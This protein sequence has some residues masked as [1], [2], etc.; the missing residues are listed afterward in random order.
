MTKKSL[1]NLPIHGS[2]QGDP[3]TRPNWVQPQGEDCAKNQ[4]CRTERNTAGGVATEEM[5][6]DSVLRVYNTRTGRAHTDR[7]LGEIFD[8]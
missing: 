8:L 4:E 6:Y 2:R 5:R 3:G 7:T 1:S